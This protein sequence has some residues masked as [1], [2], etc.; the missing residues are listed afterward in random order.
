MKFR[1]TVQDPDGIGDDVQRA[2]ESKMADVQ[3]LDADEL[4]QLRGNRQ[5]DVWEVLGQFISDEDTLVLELD[6]DKETARVV[7]VSER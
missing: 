1:I 7:P 3:G 6:T 5:V 4:V 2:I